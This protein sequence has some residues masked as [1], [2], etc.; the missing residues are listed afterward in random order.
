MPAR[1]EIMAG[2]RDF[3]YDGQ[4][5]NVPVET[6]A[7][8][9]IANT[10]SAITGGARPVV[11]DDATQYPLVAQCTALSD[12]VVFAAGEDPTAAAG[13]T[14]PDGTNNRVM[15]GVPAGQTFAMNVRPG[16]LISAVTMQTS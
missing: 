16:D 5:E 13:A 8:F 9:F 2:G 3:A 14:T 4:A 11:P 12:S 15:M 10:A 7:V 6:L 1:I